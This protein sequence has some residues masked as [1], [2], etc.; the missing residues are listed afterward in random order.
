MCIYIQRYRGASKTVSNK[1][2]ATITEKVLQFLQCKLFKI[3]D[4]KCY[5]TSFL[6]DE[7]IE[8]I[9]FLVSQ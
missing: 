3:G 7:G 9:Y 8:L 2:N 4:C 5:L 1:R 6:R